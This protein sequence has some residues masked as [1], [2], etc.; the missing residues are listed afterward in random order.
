MGPDPEPP[1][2]NER[3]REMMR[4]YNEHHWVGVTLALSLAY[5]WGEQRKEWSRVLQHGDWERVLYLL[6]RGA[7]PN[8]WQLSGA[9]LNSPLHW[10]AKA[11]APIEVVHAM[12]EHGGWRNLR[13][14]AGELPVDVAARKNHRR[15]IEAL[16]PLLLHSLNAADTAAIQGHLVMLPP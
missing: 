5:G 1:Q 2:L 16:T 7:S 3:H 10:A 4:N 13:N 8:D 12:I 9:S 15:L 14:A 6:R 11:G